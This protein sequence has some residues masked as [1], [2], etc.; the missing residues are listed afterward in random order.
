MACQVLVTSRGSA[1]INQTLARLTSFPASLA[2][3]AAGRLCRPAQAL[4]RPS[5]RIAFGKEISPVKTH[6]PAGR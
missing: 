4:R 5:I 1:V 2:E 6:P 3:N